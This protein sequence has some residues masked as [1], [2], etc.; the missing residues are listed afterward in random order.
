MLTACTP[1]THQLLDA[2]ACHASQKHKLCIGNCSVDTKVIRHKAHASSSD[3][4]IRDGPLQVIT[5]EPRM[6]H[7]GQ[8]LPHGCSI[9]FRNRQHNTQ[10]SC[11]AHD[12]RHLLHHSHGGARASNRRADSE[13]P[14]DSSRSRAPASRRSASDCVVAARCR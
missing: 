4:R 3:S 13:T 8:H 9:L 7:T 11:N 2:R 1:L 5:F 10:A 6:Y 12:S 14:M